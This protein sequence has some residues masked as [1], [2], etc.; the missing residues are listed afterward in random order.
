MKNQCLNHSCKKPAGTYSAHL[1]GIT[2]GGWVG[3]HGTG[4]TVCMMTI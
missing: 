1:D 2:V 4:V 3:N